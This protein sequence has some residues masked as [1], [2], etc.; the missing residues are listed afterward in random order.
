M[1]KILIAAFAVTL[2]S[3]QSCEE[4]DKV[5]FLD[6]TMWN[7]AYLIPPLPATAEITFKGDGK[8]LSNPNMS[9]ATWT[10]NGRDVVITFTGSRTYRGY[11]RDD[12]VIISGKIFQGTNEIGTWSAS[13]IE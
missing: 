12:N 11:L 7:L 3:F 4:K 13:K 2:L 8:L 9:A 1:K 5:P 10:Q 6:D